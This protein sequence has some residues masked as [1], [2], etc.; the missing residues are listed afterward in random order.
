MNFDPTLRGLTRAFGPPDD[1]T[2]RSWFSLAVWRAQG[3]RV[4]PVTID[5]IVVT[6]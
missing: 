4:R 2:K 3:F 5:S 6:G 1:C